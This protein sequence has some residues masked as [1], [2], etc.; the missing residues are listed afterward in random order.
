MHASGLQAAEIDPNDF[1]IKNDDIKGLPANLSGVDSDPD[2]DHE[3]DAEHDVESDK[4]GDEN[5]RS[6]PNQS[7]SIIDTTGNYAD[8]PQSPPM[9]DTIPTTPSDVIVFVPNS[10][11]PSINGDNNAPSDEVVPPSSSLNIPLDMAIPI[12]NK[13]S[14]PHTSRSPGT[15]DCFA[16]F[17]VFNVYR[18]RS[19]ASCTSTR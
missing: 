1:I 10:S 15:H 13:R 6:P 2:D 3:A 12:R 14:T 7:D 19:C 17:I 8:P 11:D 16:L 9:D 4:D 5:E 18:T